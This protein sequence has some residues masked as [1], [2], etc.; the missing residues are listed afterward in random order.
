M[1]TGGFPLYIIEA[2]RSNADLSADPPDIADVATVLQL[3]LDQATPAAR[4]I[5][6][7]AAAAGTS[8]S[9]DL[10][11][12]ASDHDAD[13]V[14]GAVDELWHRRIMRELGDG[15]D[16]SHDLLREAAYS[17]V[18]P[19]QRWLL[20]RRLAQSLELLH[21]GHT[22]AVAGLAEQYARGGRPARALEYYRQAA[23][24][25]AGMLAH[26][27]AIRLHRQALA[28]VT[29]L[30]PG[31]DADRQ[32]LAVLQAMAAPLNARLGYASA[33][34]QE[35]LE[36]AMVLAERLGATGARV[37][38]LLALWASRIVQ[39]RTADSYQTAALA[40]SL[41]DPDSEL[42]GAAHFAV[43]GSAINLGRL[44]E[45]LREMQTAA[46]LGMTTSLQVGTRPDVHALAWSAHAHWLLGD[47]GQA[48]AA[49]AGA[50]D[51]ARAAT[52]PTTWS[53]PSPIAASPS[54]CAATP[55]PW[56]AP[57]PS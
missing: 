19:A 20:H 1:T 41:V 8:F 47:A 36:R 16:F 39:G 51:L 35:V 22:D 44:A 29:R 14:V 23:D 12:E 30:P 49:A 4:D 57:S 34:L 52:T 40:R 28:I 50:V 7:L 27:D 5:A 21:A 37:A 10:L 17:T 45:G 55:G 48:A 38:G 11:T 43:G 56:P 33:E 46:A 42:A 13:V 9:L 53:W 31:R 3:R 18:S 6:G 32:E 25:A 54:R 24:V 15:Y 26:A 2:L